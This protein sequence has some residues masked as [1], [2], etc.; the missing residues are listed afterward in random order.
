[1]TEEMAHYIRYLRLGEN[2][3]YRAIAREIERAYPSLN[4]YSGDQ[5]QGYELCKEA[6]HYFKESDKFEEIWN[7][8]ENA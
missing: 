4:I 7:K 3:T 5:W 6:A 1:M 2:Y 8:K